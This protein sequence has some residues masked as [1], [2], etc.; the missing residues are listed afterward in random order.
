ML[1]DII[2]RHSGAR[3]R[4]SPESTATNDILTVWIRACA[5]R[6]IPE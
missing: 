2:R 4:A 5:R 6:R 3:V 1:L